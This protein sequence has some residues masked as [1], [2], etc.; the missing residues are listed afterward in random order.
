MF[1]QIQKVSQSINNDRT[2]Q[3]V[4]CSTMEEVGELAKEVNIEFSNSK[5]TPGSDGVVG[6][7][8]D[9]VVCLIDLLYVTHPELTE[10][11]FSQIIQNKLEKWKRKA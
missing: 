3:D 10:E 6:E 8:A 7:I 4:M 5:K 9:C 11:N 1:K 2:P